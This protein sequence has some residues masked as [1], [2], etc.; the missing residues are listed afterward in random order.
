MITIIFVPREASS[1]MSSSMDDKK[2]PKAIHLEK[3]MVT[4]LKKQNSSSDHKIQLWS[5][6]IYFVK[7]FLY[8]SKKDIYKCPKREI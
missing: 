8:I 7:D 4:T 6:N 2:T 5:Q 1:K 3:I